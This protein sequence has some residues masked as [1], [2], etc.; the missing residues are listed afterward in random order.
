M[1][2][3]PDSNFPRILTLCRFGDNFQKIYLSS[4]MTGEPILIFPQEVTFG[5]FG[6][7]NCIKFEI[8][9]SLG[10]QEEQPPSGWRFAQLEVD[11]DLDFQDDHVMSIFQP[12]SN[13]LPWP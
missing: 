11:D 9:A 1:R 10:P 7:D 8:V 3:N 12:G 4:I 2:S 5:C 6:F 13:R